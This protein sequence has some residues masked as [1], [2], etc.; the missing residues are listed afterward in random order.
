LAAETLRN[1]K[2]KK[3]TVA[4]AQLALALGEDPDAVE[5]AIDAALREN[6]GY[7]ELWTVLGHVRYTRD[8]GRWSKVQL[9]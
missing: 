2:T 9:R 5:A 3:L 8:H 7:G 6:F 1:G 4:K